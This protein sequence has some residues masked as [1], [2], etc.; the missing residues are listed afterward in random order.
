MC[1]MKTSTVRVQGPSGRL[2][3]PDFPTSTRRYWWDLT[4]G[5]YER[6]RVQEV[7][8]D[9]SKAEKRKDRLDN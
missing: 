9:V 1:W 3:V 2:E 4:N 8:Y 5:S 6:G 7:P